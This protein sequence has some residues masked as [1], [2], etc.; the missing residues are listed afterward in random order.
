MLG[1]HAPATLQNLMQALS[2]LELD[3]IHAAMEYR[4]ACRRERPHGGAPSP[5]R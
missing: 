1:R 2:E 4:S 5:A 3:V